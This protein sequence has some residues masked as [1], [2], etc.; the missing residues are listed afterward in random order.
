MTKLMAIFLS[1]PLLFLISCGEKTIPDA[2]IEEYVS[3][4]DDY[5]RGNLAATEVTL[6]GIVSKN[7]SFHQAAFL[8]AKTYYFEGKLDAAQK[9]FEDLVRAY[10]RYNEA[11]IWLARIALQKG[12]KEGAEKRLE[13]LLSFDQND[14]RLLHLMGTVYQEKGDMKNS[15]A[16]FQRASSFGEE[17]ARSHLESARLYYQFDQADKALEE[18]ELCMSL[19]PADSLLRR[20]VASLIETITKEREKK[21]SKQ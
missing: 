10:G 19:A 4:K 18:L 21:G 3:A 12:D 15:L 13:K 14:P 20:P 1:L 9:A 16:F 2:L 7:G 5:S 17:L 11:E 8:L 6:K